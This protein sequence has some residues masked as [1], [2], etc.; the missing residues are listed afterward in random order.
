MVPELTAPQL[1][2]K[3]KSPNP[4]L[5]ID[6]REQDECDFC[7]IPGGELKP[8]GGLMQWAGD[9]DP[10]AEIVCYCHTGQRSYMAAHYLRQHFKFKNVFNLEGGIDAWSVLVDPGVP[11][12]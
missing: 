5:L 6:V 7:R 2:E 11:R 4:P 3:L 8:L 10:E 12:Y 1:A 9:L